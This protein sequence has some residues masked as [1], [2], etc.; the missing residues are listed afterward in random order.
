MIDNWEREKNRNLSEVE[1]C[2]AAA[3]DLSRS[4]GPS[5]FKAASDANADQNFSLPD[6]DKML[7]AEQKRLIRLLA[8]IGFNE[9]WRK[10]GEQEGHLPEV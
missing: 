4:V 7:D 9:V 10:I 6:L 1:Q 8:Y 2:T 5:R 3:I